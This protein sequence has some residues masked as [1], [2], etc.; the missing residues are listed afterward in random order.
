[1]RVILFQNR[2]AGKVRDGSK[3]QT[4]RRTARCQL[5]DTLSLRRWTGKPRRSKQETLRTEI[6]QSVSPVIIGYGP[7]RAGISVNGVLCTMP[8][9]EALAT[10]DGFACVADMLDWFDETHGLPF[11]GVLIRWV[12]TKL[13][14]SNAGGER[15][16]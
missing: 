14:T 13:D 3:P 10:A 1:M 12:P 2:F 6:C 7:D 4:I 8:E 16:R 11:V 5:G 15:R 9:C